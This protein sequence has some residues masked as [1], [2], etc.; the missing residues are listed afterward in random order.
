MRGESPRAED[1]DMDDL[2]TLLEAA[3]RLQ[4]HIGTIRAWVRGGRLP[5]Y[6]LGRRFT[7]VSWDEVLRTMSDLQ[8]SA[9]P[10]QDLRLGG[11]QVGEAQAGEGRKP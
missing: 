11:G 8:A 4:I 3:R 10:T 7:R 6:R 9:D 5:A 1:Y 2:I